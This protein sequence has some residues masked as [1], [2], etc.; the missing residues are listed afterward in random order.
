MSDPRTEPKVGVLG[1]LAGAAH[2]RRGLVVV[3]WLVAVAAAIGLSSAVAGEFRADYTAPGS[4]SRA[5][6]DLLAERFPELTGEPLDV[7]VRS[8]AGPVTDPAVRSDVTGML[9]DIAAM[10]QVRSVANPYEEPG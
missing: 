7:V 10:P 6:Q 5:A 4:D 9:D 8:T 2:R 3:L 1:R